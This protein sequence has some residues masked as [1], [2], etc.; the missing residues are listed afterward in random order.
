MRGSKKK[1]FLSVLLFFFKEP[2]VNMK[3]MQY[4]TAVS[5]PRNFPRL[6]SYLNREKTDNFLKISRENGKFIKISRKNANFVMGVRKKHQLLPK[7]DFLT[8]HTYIININ[9]YIFF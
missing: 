8:E 3:L 2:L 5:R 6:L 7:I 9:V 1:N 4:R